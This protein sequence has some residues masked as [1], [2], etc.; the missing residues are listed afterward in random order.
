LAS[1]TIDVV[2]NAGASVTL[3]H[4]GPYRVADISGWDD[5][6]PSRVDD[7]ARANQHGSF[8]A[9][10]WS[11]ARTV[12]VEG[13][14]IDP[15]LRDQL[16]IDLGR[17]LILG[18]DDDPGE[19]AVTFAGRTLTANARLTRSSRTLKLWGPGHFGWIAEWWA[20]DPF[21]Y[22]SS[23]TGT[24]GLPEDTGGLEFPLFADGFLD[25]GDL[26]APGRITMDNPG[27]AP[28]YPVYTVTGP[29]PAGFE[30]RHV[31][32][33]RRLRWG[34]AVPTGSEITLDCRTATASFDDSPGW[35]GELTKRQWHVVPASG[36][37]T[38]QFLGLGS[39]D[40]AASLT[41]SWAPTFW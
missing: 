16:L 2:W 41:A 25:F 35:D 7:V 9:P 12:T 18:G 13:Y 24:T 10:V 34:S 31:E 6:P 21:R 39:Y 28:A 20:A 11:S 29:V 26:G 14:C 5:L 17:T 1:D 3:A 36:T 32:T 33:G 23:V 40:A 37:A 38:V 15:D 8:D 27:S 22:G 4:E 19:L 30:L